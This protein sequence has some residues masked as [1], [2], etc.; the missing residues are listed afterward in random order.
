MLSIYY[1]SSVFKQI[2][3]LDNVFFSDIEGKPQVN[4]LIPGSVLVLDQALQD[5]KNGLR[6]RLVGVKSEGTHISGGN[7]VTFTMAVE[8]TITTVVKTRMTNPG[9]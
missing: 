9:F 8:F 6:D 7:N 3:T 2:L 1:G 5:I 4:V